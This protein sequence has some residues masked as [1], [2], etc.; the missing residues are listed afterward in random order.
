MPVVFG[1][2][3]SITFPVLRGFRDAKRKLHV[4]HFDSHHDFGATTMPGND[5]EMLYSHGNHLRHA[6]DLPWVS[7]I[8]MIGLRGLRHAE[9]AAAEARKRNIQMLSASQVLQM[10][11]QKAIAQIPAAESYYVTFDIDVMDPSLAPGTGT[12]V[13]GGF[14]YYQASELLDAIA[15]RGHIAGSDMMEVS[16]PYDVNGTTSRMAAHLIMRFLA[17]VFAARSKSAR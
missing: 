12:P 3:H 17:S 16:P 4:I 2:D 5:G 15:A 10:G 6:V 9:N 11:A 8:T 1:G 14:N 13:P 7:G